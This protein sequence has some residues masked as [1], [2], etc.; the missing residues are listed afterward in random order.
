[1]Y[2]SQLSEFDGKAINLAGSIR[3]KS[4]RVATQ[5]ALY[6]QTTQKQ[7]YDNVI[8]LIRDLENTLNKPILKKDFALEQLAEQK[9]QYLAIQQNWLTYIKPQ[10]LLSLERSDL[11]EVIEPI[12]QFVD[13]I[14]RLAIGYQLVLEKR[15]SSLKL[16]QISTLFATLFFVCLS[17]YSIHQHIAVPLKE[18]TEMAKKSAKGDLTQHFK[19]IRNDELGLLA[20]TFNSYNERISRIYGD[21][22]RRVDKKTQELKLNNQILTLLYEI[23]QEVNES[24]VGEVNYERIIKQ[25]SKISG[26]NNIDLCLQT[27]NGDVPY[28]HIITKTDRIEPGTCIEKSCADCLSGESAF[29][30]LVNKQKVFQHRYAI[31][32]NAIH[33]G[34]IVVTLMP[35]QRVKL[36]QQQLLKSV[37]E[38][39]ALALGMRNQ[40]DQQRRITLLNERSIIAREL[41]DSLA[42]SLSYLKIQ[43]TRIQRVVKPYPDNKQLNDPIIELKEGLSSAYR[44]LRELLTTFRLHID[45]EGLQSAILKTIQTL[46]QQSKIKV[47]LDYKTAH[48]P[49]TPNEEIHLLQITKEALQNAINHSKGTYI[50]ICFT[51]LE[52]QQVQITIMDDGIGLDNQK[53]ELNHYGTAIMEERSHSLKGEFS[54]TNRLEG[55]AQVIFKF[56]PSY[57]A[58]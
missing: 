20:S 37:A 23:A 13:S 39:L 40:N 10:L 58:S 4:Y 35:E 46:T 38:Q 55:G 50:K 21:L 18:L 24:Q 9:A 54:L 11:T 22:E 26:L 45:S 25:V 29:V 52:N 19:A 7:Y 3:M 36:W 28:Q 2:M 12:N 33:Y 51:E 1:M 44:Q 8:S 47:N 27:S 49:Y 57:L 31:E 15:L 16:R 14:D 5:V 30:S 53:Q 43:V 42:Q 41:H 34:V 56:F 32:K 17:L 6:Q 48:I